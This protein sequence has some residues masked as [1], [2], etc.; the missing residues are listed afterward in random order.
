[1]RTSALGTLLTE[2][3]C[4]QVA[5]DIFVE[6]LLAAGDDLVHNLVQTAE[7]MEHL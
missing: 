6:I 1:M 2:T 5:A 7:V 3:L 4:V